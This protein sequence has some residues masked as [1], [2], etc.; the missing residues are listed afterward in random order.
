MTFT[1]VFTTNGRAAMKNTLILATL[2]QAWLGLLLGSALSLTACGGGGS[3]TTDP[4]APSTA[5]PG[6]ALD[7]DVR[8]FLALGSEDRV[9]QARAL[10]AKVERDWLTL[11][12]VEAELGGPA[13]TDAAYANVV[14][15][16][17]ADQATTGAPLRRLNRP[18]VQPAGALK[19][20]FGES[21][22][23]VMFVSTI[24][25]SLMAKLLLDQSKDAA[26]GQS[27]ADTFER[28][29]AVSS[30]ERLT[31]D[32]SYEHRATDPSGLVG[33]LKTHFDVV[34]CPNAD[35]VVTLKANVE[36][37][38]TRS[39]GA[40]GQKST[41]DVSVTVHVNDDAE[42]AYSDVDAHMEMA[43]FTNAKGAYVDF[44]LKYAVGSSPR[45]GSG[46]VNRTGGSITD[47]FANDAYAM[48]KIMSMLI[49]IQ[50]IDGAETA[51]K[52][53]RCVTL[54]PTTD[55]AKRTG[56][57]PSTSVAITA[58]PR[59]KIDGGPVGGAV[60]AS[61]SGE[62]AVAPSGTKVPADASF[63]YTAANTANKAGNVSLEARSRRGVAK[64]NLAFDTAEDSWIGTASY[65]DDLHRA[66]AQITWVLVNSQDNV[67]TYKATGSGTIASDDGT[68]SFPDTSGPLGTLGGG[69]LFVDFNS[70]P[71]TYHGA[72]ATGTWDVTVTCVFG[73]GRTETHVQPAALP[74][75]G[76]T[77]GPQGVEAAGTALL[78]PD[79]S[80]TIEGTDTD[81]MDGVFRWNFT[82]NR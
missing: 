33:K 7:A 30:L 81:G 24:E 57:Q 48:G 11:S 32:S 49:A 77:K 34:A 52:S 21:A 31:Y 80:M 8:D 79:G 5:Q 78:Q 50:L 38:M 65:S 35:G 37:S 27:A 53:G 51:W 71:P 75:F 42:V 73:D 39:G 70:T 22:A 3:A 12:G 25:I 14:A 26:R 55:P 4:A 58:A 74:V 64:A 18:L 60:T 69:I 44:D 19:A 40:S 72:T 29:R 28:G 46:T 16:F 66:S 59:S 47:A 41:L 82:R 9:R 1:N 67:S 63:T 61:L 13:A 62:A 36:T 45:P 56:L 6:A 68:C 20:D 54:E 17:A 76:G 10:N 2:R 23:G 15:Q 43:D